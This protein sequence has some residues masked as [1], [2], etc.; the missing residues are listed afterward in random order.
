MSNSQIYLNRIR[1]VTFSQTERTIKAPLNLQTSL[2]TQNSNLRGSTL[3]AE[4][5]AFAA[6]RLNAKRFPVL[7]RNTRLTACVRALCNS[8][9]GTCLYHRFA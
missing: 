4:T 6:C 5:T 7:L 8:L 3:I 1:R 9:G 2:R